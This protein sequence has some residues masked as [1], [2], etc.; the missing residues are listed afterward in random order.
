MST[1]RTMPGIVQQLHDQMRLAIGGAARHRGADAGRDAGIEEVDVEGE[2]QHAV[3]S[4]DALDDAADQHA[5]AEL[6]DR[7]HVGDGDAALMH[8]LLLQRIDRADAEQIEPIR[9]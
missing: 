9:A 1:E 7:A 3:R 2:M 5:D 4:P 8:Q 6:V